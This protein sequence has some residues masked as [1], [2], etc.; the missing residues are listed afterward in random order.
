[1]L[2]MVADEKLSTTQHDNL[3]CQLSGE[4]LNLFSG[5]SKLEIIT[6]IKT[7]VMQFSNV[8]KGNRNML[9]LQEKGTQE[10]YVGTSNPIFG[11]KNYIFLIQ[12]LLVYL[13]CPSFLKSQC[14]A[15]PGA[16]EHILREIFTGHAV[17]SNE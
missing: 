4:M 2:Q 9:R 12:L 16:H 6:A 15:S 5:R 8:A 1:M 7:R 10:A 13:Y 17:K 3:C 11:N 14:K